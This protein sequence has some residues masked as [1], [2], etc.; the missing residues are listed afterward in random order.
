LRPFLF[1]SAPE[2]PPPAAFQ[3]LSRIAAPASSRTSVG[4]APIIAR[5]TN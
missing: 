4:P 2:E 1:A 3:E 5:I